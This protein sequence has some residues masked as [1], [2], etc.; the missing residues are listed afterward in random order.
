MHGEATSEKQAMG[1]LCDG[2]ASLVVGTHTHVPTADHRI[3]PGGTAFMSDV[4]MTGDYES[5]IGMDK[6][7]PLGR[8]LRRI[9]TS[10]FEAATGPAT[11]CGAGG[12]DRRCDRARDQGR[13][14]A[15]RRHAGRG[16]AGILD[17][18]E[19]PMCPRVALFAVVLASWTSIAFAD[20]IEPGLWK[21]TTRVEADGVVGPPR[22]SGKCLTAEET[23]DVA[24]T[25]SPVA[26]TVNSECAPL[27]R[28]FADGKLSWKLVCKGQLDM[29]LIGEFHFDAPR[30]YS[31]ENPKHR[32]DGRA[33][34]REF[35][36]HAGCRMGVRVHPIG[37]AGA[38]GS[39]R[40]SDFHRACVL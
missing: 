4:G 26:N 14:G 34:G 7:E 25:F 39:F 19:M 21:I 2:R 3:L 40:P 10:K 17:L 16:Q 27:E 11:L 37:T 15:A 35:A 31:A 8:F 24:K 12:R 32:G 1:Y 6:D 20:D 5:V 29:E 23:R 18:R 38:A 28:S 9:P 36:E 22:E 13:S 30:H 33:A